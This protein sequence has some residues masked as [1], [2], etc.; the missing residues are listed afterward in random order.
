MNLEKNPESDNS[1]DERLVNSEP[2]N[3]SEKASEKVV[4]HKIMMRLFLK[5]I[6]KKKK[7]KR[8]PLLQAF[9]KY[10]QEYFLSTKE[11]VE[12]N[13]KRYAGLV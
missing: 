8:F 6:M 11:I 4:C 9:G 1:L 2:S 5:A 3:S 12:P 7:K 13:R 10:A